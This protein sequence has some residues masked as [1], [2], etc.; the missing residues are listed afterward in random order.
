MTCALSF[1]TLCLISSEGFIVTADISQ[2]VNQP[3]YEGAWCGHEKIG[4]YCRGPRVDLSLGMTVTI[5]DSFTAEYGVRHSSYLMEGDRGQE[6]VFVRV[7][8]RP[9]RQ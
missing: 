3:K 8:W 6:S 9:F 4:R 5:S 2:P 7:Q 1:A